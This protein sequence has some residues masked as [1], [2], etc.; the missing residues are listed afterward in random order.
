VAIAGVQRVAKGANAAT[1]S[2]GSGDGWATPTAGNLLVISANSDAL[3][4]LNAP[5]GVTAGPSVIDGN[6]TYTWYKNAA[7]TESTITAT[8]SASDHITLT[9]CE[10]SGVSASPFD[11]QN[12]STAVSSAA[13]VTVA[14]TATT[15]TAGDLIVAYA[16]LHSQAGQPVSPSWS[17]SFSQ[18][19]AGNSPSGTSAS[20][21]TFVGELIA[22]AAGGYST[23]CTWTSAT[24][25]DRQHIILAFKAAAGSAFVARP[26][27]VAG[28]A[29]RRASIY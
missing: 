6:G 3:V 12:S 10:Y 21:T 5:T 22:G 15:T 29:I 19:L 13:F 14:A 28:Q 2:I 25:S 9:V 11:A 17:N 23:V 4:T 16:L 27:L 1:L 18:V 8:P 26:P 20:T 24:A 7:G